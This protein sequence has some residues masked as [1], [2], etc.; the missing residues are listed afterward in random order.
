MRQKI[1]ET[2]SLE[3]AS[4]VDDL[5]LKGILIRKKIQF[6][7]GIFKEI[8]WILPFCPS[9]H[10]LN[11]KFASF[12]LILVDI[13]FAHTLEVNCTLQKVELDTYKGF[14]YLKNI[15]FPQYQITI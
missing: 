9:N 3:M 7:C 2:S 13:W 1:I 8:P 15:W 10:V 14:A 6:F 5:P 4:L 11:K 12:V